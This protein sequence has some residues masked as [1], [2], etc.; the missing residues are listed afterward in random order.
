MNILTDLFTG[1]D[2]ETI[3]IGRVYSLPV[4]IVGLAIPV[5]Q[6]A[7]GEVID[8]LELG[9]LLGGVGGAVMMMVAGTNNVDN[10][11]LD[12]LQRAARPNRQT[13]FSG[14]QNLGY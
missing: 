6:V 1:P 14:G 5:I 2:G 12:T 13:R 8:L 3:A 9:A 10:P 7:Q 4:L 11:I